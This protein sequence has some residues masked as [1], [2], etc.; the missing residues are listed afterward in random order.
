M[1]CRNSDAALIKASIPIQFGTLVRTTSSSNCEA[2]ATDLTVNHS[3]PTL[4]VTSSWTSV[5]ENETLHKMGSTTGWTYGAVEDKCA[6]YSTSGWIKLCA[7][8]VDFSIDN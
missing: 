7:D 4:L 2:C 6:D 1:Q 5:I 8:R 3:S